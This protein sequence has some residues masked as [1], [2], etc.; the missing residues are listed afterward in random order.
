M[1]LDATQ[2]AS[3]CRILQVTPSQLDSQ[4]EW[5]GTAFTSTLEL[6]VED[7]MD[8]WTAGAGT[9]FTRIQANERNFGAE[10]DPNLEKADIRRNIAILLER[11]DWGGSGS[12]IM[13]G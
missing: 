10:I 8:R 5:L 1:A 4:I 3:L 9:K 7:E 6:A 2:K 13:R 12:R 11:P